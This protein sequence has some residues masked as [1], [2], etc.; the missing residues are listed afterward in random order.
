ME[1]GG[2]GNIF[3]ILRAQSGVDF[4]LYK[5]AIL[6]R[7]IRR[8][9]AALSIES[10]EDY[11]SHLRSHPSETRA[12][13]ND[14]MVVV[15]GFFRVPAAFKWLKKGQTSEPAHGKHPDEEY[16]EPAA[17]GG[18]IGSKQPKEPQK[19]GG[20]IDT[21]ALKSWSSELAELEQG[22]ATF[23][24]L[25]KALVDS[26]EDAI[27]VKDLNGII[28]TWNKGAE[29]LYGY[30]AEEVVGKPGANLIPT[31]L[32]EEVPLLLLRIRSGQRIDHYETVRIHKDGRRVDISLSISP[33]INARG[34]VIAASGIA[35]DITERKRWEEELRRAH[36]EEEKANRA[37]DDFL[38][39]LSHELRTPLNPV[40]LLAGESASDGKLPEQVRANFDVIRR[41]IELEARLIDDLLDLTR[42]RAGKLK[43]DRSDVSIHT[44]LSDTLSMVQ[45]EIEQ[46][47]IILKQD[48][49]DLE[50]IVSGD[51]VRLRQILWNILKNAIKFTPSHGTISVQ[52]RPEHGQSVIKISDTGIGMTP[53]ELASAFE[54]FK[55]GNH[56]HD[57]HRFGGLGLGLAICKRFIELHSG[58]IEAFS[59]GLGRGSTFVIKFPLVRNRL[60]VLDLPAIQ[61]LHDGHE[62]GKPHH[63]AKILLVEDH[64]PTRS[65]LAEILKRRHHTVATAASA[66]EAIAIAEK[67]E[68]DLIISDIG[69]PDGNGYELFEKIRAKSPVVKGIALSGYG[70]DHDLV[71]SRNFGFKTHLIKPVRV[72]AL[73]E[74]LEETLAD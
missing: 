43:I 12:L 66:H 8:R 53:D 57:P 28:R 24:S 23:P 37:K 56:S 72:Q 64:E 2:L 4:G 74:A 25:F 19:D 13:L 45:S 62:T 41:N 49:N 63:C 33:I 10:V 69:L 67:K 54:D 17:S 51:A 58:S 18:P 27:I 11:E 20:G 70:M 29:K 50:C 30:V 14:V 35:R 32:R 21:E 34:Q 44:V 39:V 61:R 73:E 59:D 46:K 60:S 68:F 65:T 71:R 42:V 38:A 22:G 48:L 7:R 5:E 40:L 3:G 1:Q 6:R 16:A 26:S 31:E 55:Q 15:A 36:F 52:S 47:Q 9:M